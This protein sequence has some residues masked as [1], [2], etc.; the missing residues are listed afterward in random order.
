[1]TSLIFDWFRNISGDNG[2][3]RRNISFTT[4]YLKSSSLVNGNESDLQRMVSKAKSIFNA[5]NIAYNQYSWAYL[6][7]NLHHFPLA[8]VFFLE[9]CKENIIIG[10]ELSRAQKQLLNDAG[11]IYIDLRTHPIRFLTDYHLCAATNDSR[12]HEKLVALLPSNDNYIQYHVNFFKARAGRRYTKRLNPLHGIIFFAQTSFD[13]SRIYKGQFLDNAFIIAELAKFLAIEKPKNFYVK[14]HPHEDISADFNKEL[15]KVQGKEISTNTYDLLSVEGLRVCSLSSSVCHEASYFGAIPTIF[16]PCPEKYSYI[17]ESS[18]P[19]EYIL[20][21]A[22]IYEKEVW[23][24]I[25]RDK[26]KPYA[27]YPMPLR[28]YAHSSGLSWG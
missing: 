11:K 1:M 3:L 6:Y 24:F 25:L 20:L 28:P 13:S 19:G 18:Q 8:S 14:S 17:G 23:D 10:F 27:N 4:N 26:S 16:M 7:D 5:L 15:N 12:I 2:I 9:G 22:N 21:P